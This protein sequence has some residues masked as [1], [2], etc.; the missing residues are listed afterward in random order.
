[1]GATV[2]ETLPK[3]RE[4][5]EDGTGFTIDLLGEAVLSD[6]EA[7]AYAARYHD[8]IEGLAKSAT[9]DEVRDPLRQPNISLKLSALTSHFEPAAPVATSTSVLRRLVPLLEQ[10]RTLGVFVNVDMEQER[11]RELVHTIFADAL[12]LPSLSS[13]DGAGIVV[14]AYLV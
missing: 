11:Y 8:L 4:L 13:W 3:L 10:A 12:T 6:V 7:D 14:Q 5:L 1:G 2:A 9:P